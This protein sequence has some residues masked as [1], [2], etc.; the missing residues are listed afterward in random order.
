MTLSLPYLEKHRPRYLDD[1][2]GQDSIVSATKEMLPNIFEFPHVQCS[3]SPGIG[4]STW[5]EA[6]KR[7]VYGK[8]GED[9]IHEIVCEIN[10]SEERKIDTVRDKILTYC[11]IATPRYDIP[12]KMVVLEE[13][14]SFLGTSQSALRRPMELY[15]PNVIFIITCNY[16]RKIIPAIRSRC[17]QF[18]F[19]KPKPE[20]IAEYITRVAAK[21]SII[22][23]K[24]ALDLISK[25]S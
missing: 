24:P 25:N 14:D 23:E 18:R 20:H 2:I 11:K 6:L 19:H 22:V 17:A 1:I 7:A 9:A 5:V 4:K 21:E 8:F 3:G 13:F 15:S 16:P 10:A 12:R